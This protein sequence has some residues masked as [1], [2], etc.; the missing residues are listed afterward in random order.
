MELINVRI[1][2]SI[3]EVGKAFQHVL[4]QMILLL[5]CSQQNKM[6][7]CNLHV[8]LSKHMAERLG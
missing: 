8:V 5:V 6:E 4:F 3:S 7:A 2:D 1:L